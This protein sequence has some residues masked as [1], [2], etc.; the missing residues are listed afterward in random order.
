MAARSQL[1][2]DL[3]RHSYGSSVRSVAR[4]ETISLENIPES[5]VVAS[6]A[7]LVE[8]DRQ[9]AALLVHVEFHDEP[10]PFQ[11]VGNRQRRQ[12]HLDRCRRVVRL[13]SATRAG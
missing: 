9:D 4:A 8:I 12:K 10:M 2:Y 11:L 3:P 1:C 6:V 5:P 7:R 13:A